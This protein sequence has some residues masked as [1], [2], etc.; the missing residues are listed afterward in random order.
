MAATQIWPIEGIALNAAGDSVTGSLGDRVA[1]LGAYFSEKMK[2]WPTLLAGNAVVS[3]NANWTLGAKAIIIPATTITVPYY[4]HA[5]VIETCSKNAVFE[6]VLYQGAGDEEVAR[7]RF[8]VSG[9]F[10]GNFFTM[11]GPLIPANA[12]IQAALACDTGLALQATITMSLCYHEA[13]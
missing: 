9:G 1:I 8:A 7:L 10:F 11:N 5:V 4:L 12:R 13:V 3:A 6:M 2:V